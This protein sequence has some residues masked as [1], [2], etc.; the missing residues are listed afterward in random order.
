MAQLFHSDERACDA[1]SRAHEL[2]GALAVGLQTLKRIADHIRQIV[3]QLSLQY[4][5][6]AHDRDVQRLSGPEQRCFFAVDPLVDAR[7]RFAHSEIERQ[8]DDLKMVIVST[9][10][11]CS[12]DQFFEIQV[13]G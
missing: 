2:Q 11:A 8:L 9:C 6:A 12:P 10:L 5:S 13:P 1:R 4:R 7:E 3:R